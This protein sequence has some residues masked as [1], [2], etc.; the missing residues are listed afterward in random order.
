MD[1][2]VQNKGDLRQ[3]QHDNMVTAFVICIVI[4]QQPSA[5]RISKLS[6]VE[7]HNCKRMTTVIAKDDRQQVAIGRRW[8][9]PWYW[10]RSHK[11]PGNTFTQ[12]AHKIAAHASQSLPDMHRRSLPNPDRG[13][14]AVASSEEIVRSSALIQVTQELDDEKTKLRRQLHKNLPPRPSHG[15]TSSPSGIA[16]GQQISFPDHRPCTYCSSTITNH[17]DDIKTR[18]RVTASHTPLSIFPLRGLLIG[19][20]LGA[21]FCIIVHKLMLTA[22]LFPTFN[23]SAGRSPACMIEPRMHACMGREEPCMHGQVGAPPACMGR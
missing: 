19:T 8:I 14:E 5:N 9:N 2:L 12:L 15:W 7:S 16:T 17:D 11:L 22:G 21:V 13:N 3:G 1:D 20:G 23:T 4:C 10:A 6:E 18:P